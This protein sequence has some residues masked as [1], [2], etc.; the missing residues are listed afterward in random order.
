[1]LKIVIVGSGLV[2]EKAL[3]KARLQ[4]RVIKDRKPAR[5]G[6]CV[7]GLKVDRCL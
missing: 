5:E 2:P 4:G 3:E 7:W 1:M 6:V